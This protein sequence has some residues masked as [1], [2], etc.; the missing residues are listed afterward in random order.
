[1]Y[2]TTSLVS[3]LVLL[4]IGRAL[5]ASKGMPERSAEAL[6]QVVLVV[7][8]PASILLY[9]SKLRIDAGVLRV[10]AVPWLLM[11]AGT[12]VVW[13]VSRLARW[14]EAVESV[15]LLAVALGNTA[16]LGYPLVSA[17]AG[18]ASM[19]PAVLYDQLGTFLILPTYGLV[20]LAQAAHGRRPTLAEVATQVLR[21]PPVLALLVA[22]TL[23][24]DPLDPAVESVLRRL[25]DA[26]LPLVAISVG[27]QLR[28]RLAREELAPLALGLALKLVLLPLLALL[29][30]GALAL[31]AP[32]RSAVVLQA[33]M[34]TMITAM[35]LAAARGLAPRLAAAIVGYGVVLSALLLPLW[36]ALVHG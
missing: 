12:L 16:F 23:V 8:L 19:P 32:A 6:N 22:L 14:P 36:A 34:P 24:P 10:V 29:L 26:L 33:A 20:V 35:S 2:A 18:E 17:L 31:D 11:I 3:T 15:L 25:S 1:M 30:A 21:F 9:A 7:L 5:A 28:F 4:A 27:L 13:G